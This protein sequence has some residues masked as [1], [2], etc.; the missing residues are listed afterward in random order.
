MPVCV[1]RS[2]WMVAVLNF[3]EMTMYIYNSD[4]SPTYVERMER[5]LSAL[6]GHLAEFL[7]RVGESS[8]AERARGI[9]FCWRTDIPQSTFIGESGPWTCQAISV[10]GVDGIPSC[11][12]MVDTPLRTRHMMA[13]VLWQMHT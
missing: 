13:S 3:A 12:T 11:Q 2:H 4:P 5:L 9:S 10:L 1:L 6:P 8:R 7:E